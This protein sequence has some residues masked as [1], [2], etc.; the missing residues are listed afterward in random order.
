MWEW[1]AHLYIYVQVNN[2]FLYFMYMFFWVIAVSNVYLRK[3]AIVHKFN[4]ISTYIRRIY[5]NKKVDKLLSKSVPKNQNWYNRSY[6]FNLLHSTIIYTRMCVT[7]CACPASDRVY[8]CWL[9]VLHSAVC[10]TCI[11]DEC[12]RR[13]IEC[14][15]YYVWS[16]GCAA[17]LLLL[18]RLRQR[19]SWTLY[20][21][22]LYE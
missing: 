19:M 6:T 16:S 13:C 20:T 3:I 7:T 18:L 8:V 15:T 14:I 22:G 2:N 1:S 4:F 10:C 11:C 12:R 5:I 17:V 9:A 21:L